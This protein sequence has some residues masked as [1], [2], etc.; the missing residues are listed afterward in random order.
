MCDSFDCFIPACQEGD[1]GFLTLSRSASLRR[2]IPEEPPPDY[3]G[4]S[5]A[6]SFNPAELSDD[7][8]DEDTFI[9]AAPPSYDVAVE[10]SP[11]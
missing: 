6:R 9:T 5:G 3:A 7:S 1:L 8:D 11:E 4:L 2:A 10:L